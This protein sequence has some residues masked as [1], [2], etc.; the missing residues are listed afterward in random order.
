MKHLLIILSVFL[1]SVL[2]VSPVSAQSSM[3]SAAEKYW[4][5]IPDHTDIDL[6]D[7]CIEKYPNTEIAKLAFLT[8]FFLLEQNPTID[9]YNNFLAKYPQK[10]QSQV[11]L[12]DLFNLYKE[13]NRATAWCDFLQRYPATQQGLAAKLHLQTLMAQF[14]VL[15][16][17]EE[18]YDEFIGTFPD[19]P[20]IRTII[21]LAE[22]KVK[23][24]EET[25]FKELD[26]DA[27]KEKHINAILYDWEDWHTK[28]APIYPPGSKASIIE[29]GEVL[30]LSTRICRYSNVVIPLYKEYS[31]A[32]RKRAEE[33]HQE[34][35]KKLD[36]IQQTLINNHKELVKTI[37]DESAKTR[38]TIREEFAKL[39][40]KL[41]AGFEMLGKKM[42]VLHNDMVSVYQELQKV[43]LNLENIHAAIQESNRCLERLGNSLDETRNVIIEGFV[44]TN[45]NLD[46]LSDQVDNL[47]SE[48]VDFKIQSVARLDKVIANQDR[49]YNLDLQRFETER[50]HLAV[51]EETLV[52]TKGIRQNQE[53]MIELLVYYMSSR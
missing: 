51:A 23:A 27:L 2:F 15:C 4:N 30:L 26:S 49:S 50:Q 40:L 35:M 19:A 21:A 38:E 31:P 1:G 47:T 41:N 43:N 3:E 37:R 36:S 48:V 29:N 10:F 33:R 16:D 52:E 44:A 7:Q 20:Q 46:R 14:A 13:Q 5:A 9:G 22:K 53:V 17:T 8:R 6:L 39:G 42:D 11:A 25:K 32:G 34:L 24:R 28:L 45:S 18:T 12:Q